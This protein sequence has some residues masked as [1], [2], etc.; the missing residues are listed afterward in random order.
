MAWR[1]NGKDVDWGDITDVS[2]LQA[3]DEKHISR[4]VRVYD[5]PLPF[6]E[7]S[8]SRL[9]RM[10]HIS[11]VTTYFSFPKGP[12]LRRI[13]ADLYEDLRTNEVCKYRHIE[14]RSQCSQSIHRTLFRVRAI[15]NTNVLVPSHCRWVTLTYR[16]NMCDTRQ[17]YSDFS[18]FW[19]RFRRFCAKMD[20]GKPEYICVIEPQGRGAWHVHAFFLWASEAPFVANN[21]VLEPLWGHG[22]TSCRAV[23]GAIDDIGAY[24]SAYLADVEL[25]AFERLPEE[26][27]QKALARGPLEI[28]PQEILDYD[29]KLVKK[30]IV[31]GAR[32]H[33]YPPRMQILRKSKGIRL[34]TEERTTYGAALQDV[35]GARLTYRRVYEVVERD[36]DTGAEERIN[37]ISKEY[38]N[39]RRQ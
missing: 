20:W 13:S 14:N 27:R 30:R 23:S 37:L 36:D 31:K 8:P 17:L 28:V 21:E 12:P 33:M 24:F 25:S 32:L 18:A 7:R 6:L 16:D 19:K 35:E 11:E 29:G 22:F 2:E 15:I 4:F 34:P 38:Y 5:G 1:D 39:E 10:G 26:V 9:L 3:D